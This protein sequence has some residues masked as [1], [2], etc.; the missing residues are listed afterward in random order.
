MYLVKGRVLGQPVVGL[1]EVP[2]A[3]VVG[4]GVQQVARAREGVEGCKEGVLEELAECPE[5]GEERGKEGR[6]VGR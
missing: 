4:A 2:P 3:T 5:E 6:L 1:D